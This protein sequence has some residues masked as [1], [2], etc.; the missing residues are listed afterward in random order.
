MTRPLGSLG[1]TGPAGSQETWLFSHRLYP[2]PLPHCTMVLSM[3]GGHPV[4]LSS[5]RWNPWSPVGC[6]WACLPP[7]PR[8]CQAGV[9]CFTSFWEPLIRV[10]PQGGHPL[11]KLELCVTLSRHFLRWH[12]DYESSLGCVIGCSVTCCLPA[13][14]ISHDFILYSSVTS[15]VEYR[16]MCL[17][18]ICISSLVKCLF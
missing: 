5:W 9:W 4:L 14:M 16:F 10:L 8:W 1:M 11:I 7:H 17:F 2:N 18:A 12:S 6:V 13:H 3:G 15:D